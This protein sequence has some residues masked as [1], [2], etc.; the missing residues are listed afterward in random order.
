MKIRIFLF[1]RVSPM[2]D[3]LWDPMSPALF[4]RIVAYLGKSYEVVPLERTLIGDHIPLSKKELCAITFDDG[5]KDFINYAFPI[6]KKHNCPSSMYVI[7]DCVD[8][9]LPPWTYII[10]HL[11]INTSHLLLD[12]HS[13]ALP[14][15]LSKTTWNN[16][17]ERIGY[18]R[19]L[20]PFMKQL[21]NRERV[22][23][24]EQIQKEFNDVDDPHDMM[25]SW[26]NIREIGRNGCEIGSHSASHPL[27]AKKT[28]E[29]E[30]E[31]TASA[32]KIKTET[33]KFPLAISYP[34]GN[35]NDTVKTMS[36]NAGYKTGLTVNYGTY[37]SDVH[38]LFEIPRIELYSESFFKSRLRIKGYIEN[39]RKIIKLK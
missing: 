8:Q 22:L 20:S 7:S 32:E 38:H 39:T 13:K 6:L 15:N 35:Y 33:G 1:H 27:L 11:F 2:R 12:I 26:D 24:Y 30:H 9:N 21:N 29:L 17:K 37:N 4:E 23:I 25:M 28:N 31:L 5:Y 16:S 14:A 19:K 36:E 34:F 10:N 18:A 3:P